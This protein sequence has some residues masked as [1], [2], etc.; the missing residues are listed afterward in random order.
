VG[1]GLTAAVL[2]APA[3]AASSIAAKSMLKATLRSSRTSA[4]LV[5]DVRRLAKG[6]RG[7]A[8][9]ADASGEL[10]D[11]R[12]VAGARATLAVLRQADGVADLPFYRRVAR[13]FGDR[14]AGV[15]TVLGK[16]TKRAF[17]V[18]KASRPVVAMTVG[19]A[20]LL[21]ASIG[22]LLLSLSTWASTRL[23]R[24]VLTRIARGGTALAP[25]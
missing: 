25:V 5:G 7:L 6:R 15:V 18:Y 1:L 23:A 8:V 17:R 12:K 9:L 13:T 21:A 2:L 24:F 11:I 3:P 20:G 16:D 4:G 19:F 22:G 14:T 10:A